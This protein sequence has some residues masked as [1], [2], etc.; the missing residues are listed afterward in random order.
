MQRYTLADVRSPKPFKVPAPDLPD[1]KVRRPIRYRTPDDQP[2][3]AA[4]ARS[5]REIG[6]S[7]YPAPAGTAQREFSPNAR[8]WHQKRGRYSSS[9]AT[10][11][12]TVMAGA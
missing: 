1:I 11:R 8:R 6:A 7:G 10:R 9:Q 4:L 3:R 12:G 5:T 2:A